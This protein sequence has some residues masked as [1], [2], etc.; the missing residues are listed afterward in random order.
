MIVL[1]SAGR[2]LGTPLR[3]PAQLSLDAGVYTFNAIN[4]GTISHAL[5]LTGN[6]IDRHTTD[7]AFG[8][9][10]SEGL[11]VTLKPGTYQFFCPIDGHR[12]LGVLGTL[13]VH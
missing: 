12:G 11:S 2:R 7:L 5:E 8:P 6:G 1:T 4:D 3:S 10:H 13:V 9:G